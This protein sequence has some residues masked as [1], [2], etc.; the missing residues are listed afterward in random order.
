MQFANILFND[1]YLCFVYFS[2]LLLACFS[3]N[4]SV[5]CLSA[6]PLSNHFALLYLVRSQWRGGGG[7][8]GGRGATL[9][10]KEDTQ[11]FLQSEYCRLFAFKRALQRRKGAR[12]HGHPRTP[13]PQLSP[14]VIVDQGEN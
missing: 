7:E 14:S 2:F 8:G 4:L 13:R 1:F 6:K 11:Q 5:S 10:Q 9:C 3:V 12:G